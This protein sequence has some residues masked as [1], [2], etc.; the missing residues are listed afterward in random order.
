MGKIP[1]IK[2]SIREN[3]PL[4]ISFGISGTATSMRFP[5]CMAK[6][7][8]LLL[9]ETNRRADHL[10]TVMLTG[11]TALVRGTAAYM[12]NFG[13][14]Y[15]ARDIGPWLREADILH[16]SNEIAFAE[17][18]PSPSNWDGLKFCSQARYIQLLEDIG[19]DVIDLSGD[20]FAD[21]GPEAMLFSLDLYR[22]QRL[23]RIRR[24]R[25]HRRS[26]KAGFVRAQWK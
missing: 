8:A 2:T 15:P 5:P 25:E 18:C 6:L 26:P 14:D 23:A 13:M 19:T 11:V 24:R 12:E 3:Y 10:T 22:Q 21:W 20:H 1:F 16:I 7:S 4:T 9:P 17:N